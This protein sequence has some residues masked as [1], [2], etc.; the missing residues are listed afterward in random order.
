VIE[1]EGIADCEDTLTHEQICGLADG[2]WNETIFRR[3]DLQN[4]EIFFGS[5]ADDGRFPFGL[6]G[7]RNLEDRSL[8]DHVEIRDDVSLVVPDE[9]TAGALWDLLNVE[10]EEVALQCDARDEH[11]G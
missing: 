10:R 8:S 4:G 11:D 6:I 5:F 9:P 2:E 1:A 3:G 7:E